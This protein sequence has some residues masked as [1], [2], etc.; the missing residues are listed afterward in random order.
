[1]YSP[2]PKYYDSTV[3]N[4]KYNT[5][6]IESWGAYV[7]SGVYMYKSNVLKFNILRRIAAF[8]I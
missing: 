4:N 3:D 7:V 2:V 1:M 6:N 5:G 8:M